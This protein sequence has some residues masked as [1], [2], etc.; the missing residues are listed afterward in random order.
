MKKILAVVVTV[1][2]L[3]AVAL[4]CASADSPYDK[5][6]LLGDSITYGYG[7]DGACDSDRLYGRLLKEHYGISDENYKNAAVN[8]YNSTNLLSLLPSLSEEIANADLI[9]I[10]IGGNDLL[11]LI[12]EAANYVLDGGYRGP[13]Q[14]QG[15]VSD[16]ALRDEMMS[17]LT[18]SRISSAIFTYGLNLSAIAKTLR[19]SNPDAEIIFLAQYDPFGV[20][21]FDYMASLSSTAIGMLN[22]TMKA[23][24]EAGGCS[25]LDIYTPFVGHAAE[26]TYI[27][28]F[29]IHPNE[30][31]HGQ[32]F[33]IIKDYLEQKSIETSTE[34]SAE[35]TAPIIPDVATGE[36]TVGST[37]TDEVSSA[38][39]TSLQTEDIEST[40]GDS[41]DTEPFSSAMP[42]TSE[43]SE[44]ER[45]A[46]ITG[47]DE[48]PDGGCA[49]VISGGLTPAAIILLCSVAA[50]VTLKG[51]KIK[52]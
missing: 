16:P 13:D 49:G 1:A 51:S 43:P 48:L 24:V 41:A 9:V 37:A 32:I 52:D 35:T 25:Y 17:Y 10:S 47:S 11:E 20:E 19:V 30:V 33:N 44:S 28:D 3:L 21:E 23:Q 34:T 29:A 36:S 14:L 18:P 6:L 40:D 45:A 12:W 8:L 50:A 42:V 5:L 38:P 22:S 46:K 27:N 26:W 31:G 2:V 7:L 39:E 4:P 15:I